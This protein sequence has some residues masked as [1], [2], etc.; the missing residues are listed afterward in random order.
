MLFGEQEMAECHVEVKFGVGAVAAD[1]HASHVEIV[2]LKEVGDARVV[3]RDG[4]DLV[5]AVVREHLPVVG[6]FTVAVECAVV[7]R[8]SVQVDVVVE[9]LT[10]GR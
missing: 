7:P 5:F 3:A 4:V 1:D 2:A 6:G 10:T 8:P 9:K